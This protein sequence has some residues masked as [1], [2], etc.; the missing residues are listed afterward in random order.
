MPNIIFSSI[1]AET[2]RFAQ[3]FVLTWVQ[4]QCHNMIYKRVYNFIKQFIYLL[5][6]AD[7]WTNVGVFAYERLVSS[8][9]VLTGTELGADHR[10]LRC[11]G[12][13]LG[14]GHHLCCWRGQGVTGSVGSSNMGRRP[15]EKCVSDSALSPNLII[16][17]H[18]IAWMARHSG[19]HLF[20]SPAPPPDTHMSNYRV[21][22]KVSHYQV[23]SFNR[24]E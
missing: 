5:W 7:M 17:T 20:S 22:Q 4:R 13:R 8:S 2:S 24:I 15:A 16:L 10:V 11:G 14:W 21:A 18:D 1:W 9:D 19:G 23:S 6:I 3:Y 12:H